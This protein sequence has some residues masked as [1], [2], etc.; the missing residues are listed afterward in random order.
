MA[1]IRQPNIALPAT[2]QE[3]DFL[4]THGG[5]PVGR[6][7]RRQGALRTDGMWLWAINGVPGGPEPFGLA[8]TSSS[9]EEAEAKMNAGWHRWLAWAGL[10]EAKTIT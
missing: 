8:G 3:E 10:V 7:C 6:I 1:L 5:M 4:L 9:L 2:L